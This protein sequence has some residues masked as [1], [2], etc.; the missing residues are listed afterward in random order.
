[1]F[2]KHVA[3][4]VLLTIALTLVLAACAV[5]AGAPAAQAPAQ[6]PA[7]EK[8]RIA[9]VLPSTID[10]LAWSQGMYEGAKAVQAELGEDVVELAVSERLGNPV[11]AGAAIRDYASQGFDI[12]IAHGSQYQSTLMEIAKDFPDTSFAYGTAFETTDNIFAYD[13]QAQEGAYLLGIIAAHVTKSKIVGIVG[14]VEAGDAIKYNIGF[15]QGVASVDPDIQVLIAYTGSFGDNVQAGELANTEMDNGADVLTGT[16][17][18]TVGA[19]Q[20]VAQR[21]GVYWLSND[22][23]QS[24]LAPDVVLA[25]QV[26]QWKDIVR[27]MVDA[28]REGKKGGEHLTLSLANGRLQIV[29]NPRLADV[30]PQA[31]KDQVEATAQKIISGELKIELPKE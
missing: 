10:D 15:Q 31:V 6:A 22:M 26:Y 12:V 3:V 1:M 19:I 9:L 14:P 30:I 18:Q 17:Q 8:I 11:D 4:W 21:E 7:Q 28:R 24:S 29:Y 13:P 16:A 27:R 5:P 25:S 2:R 23:D 20:A